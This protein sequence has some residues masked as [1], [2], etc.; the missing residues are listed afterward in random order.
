MRNA[1]IALPL[2]SVLLK[3][4]LTRVFLLIEPHKEVT[5]DNIVSVITEPVIRSCVKQ[6]QVC[7]CVRYN[8]NVSS[9]N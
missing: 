1:P 9:D 7:V 5:I 6:C 8:F 3:Q 4:Q 2:F